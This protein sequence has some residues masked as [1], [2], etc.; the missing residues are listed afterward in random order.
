MKRI[1]RVT[2]P[3]DAS[4]F[5]S[6][7]QKAADSKHRTGTLNAATDWKSARQTK[8]MV[9]VLATL[10]AMT[11]ERQRCMYCLD[12]HGS[13][14][15]HFR[16][17]SVYPKHIYRWNNLLLCC[18]HCGRL[19]GEQF[20]LS[21]RSALL[22]DPTKENSWD[23]LDFDPQTGNICARF[24][25]QLN[26]WSSKG[27][28]TVEVLHLDT[29]EALSAGYLQTLRRLSAII[30]ST[31]TTGVVNAVNLIVSLKTADDHG[32]LG[33]CFGGLADRVPPFS[34]LR[35]QH[36]RV[37]AQCVKALKG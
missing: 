18:T 24:D 30:E 29:R 6:A 37:W 9:K 35:Q 33:W 14:I 25:V 8:R 19:K 26:A 28:K 1:K 3:K 10:H 36:P 20:P 11:G 13:D 12:S 16:P 5:L 21:N 15:E 22:I 17:K 7:R 2:L 27:E 4:N 23:S 32:L 31:L 34:D